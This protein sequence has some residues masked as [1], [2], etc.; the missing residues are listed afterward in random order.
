MRK[1]AFFLPVLFFSIL[2]LLSMMCFIPSAEAKSGVQC[3]T[4]DGTGCDMGICDYC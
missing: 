1:S 4:P 2:I 3:V